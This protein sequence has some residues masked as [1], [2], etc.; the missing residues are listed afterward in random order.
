GILILTEFNHSRPIG[1]AHADICC[2][3]VRQRHGGTRPVPLAHFRPLPSPS[4]HRET[5]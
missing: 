3:V 5:Y 4:N 2:L 1:G